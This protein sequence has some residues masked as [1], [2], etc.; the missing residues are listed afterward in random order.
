MQM[1][2]QLNTLLVVVVV[3]LGECVVFFLS[4]Q[5]SR[6]KVGHIFVYCLVCGMHSQFAIR[7]PFVIRFTVN[8]RLTNLRLKAVKTRRSMLTF[9]F[10][11]SL[12]S[13]HCSLSLF[14]AFLVCPLCSGLVQFIRFRFVA[15]NVCIGCSRTHWN[16]ILTEVKCV[17]REHF[18]QT[19][20]LPRVRVRARSLTLTPT[21]THTHTHTLTCICAITQTETQTH[22]GCK[23]ICAEHMLKYS[24]A[25]PPV[26]QIQA[27]ALLIYL[28]MLLQSITF[29]A[30]VWIINLNSSCL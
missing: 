3:V 2:L 16:S 17:P 6:L 11:L 5:Q 14:F 8:V 28:L 20:S 7:L 23:D 9:F 19:L 24:P 25:L 13:F 26:R 4:A 15:H 10:G 21:H 1:H 27:R 18:R 29:I 30:A 12:F 22:D